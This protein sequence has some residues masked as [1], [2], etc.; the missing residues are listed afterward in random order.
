[1]QKAVDCRNVPHQVATAKWILATKRPAYYIEPRRASENS[2][3]IN[4]TNGNMVRTSLSL[5]RLPAFALMAVWLIGCSQVEPGDA[6]SSTGS[7]SSGKNTASERGATAYQQG[8]A[9][10]E[11]LEFDKAIEFLS[12]AIKEDDQNAD[13]YF[14]IG[15]CLAMQKRDNEAIANLDQAIAMKPDFAEAYCKRGTIHCDHER[16]D[17]GQADLEKA[18]TLDPSLADGQFLLGLILWSIRDNPSA[19]LPHLDKAA[20]LDPQNGGI[21]KSRALVHK[22]LGNLTEAEEDS[23]RARKLGA[24]P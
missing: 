22:Q 14:R 18:V 7:G 15:V 6:A 1:M 16:N 4:S 5:A 8:I 9:A 21:Y 10:Q 19:A 20:E 2:L 24:S 23:L 3:L 17:A 11:R 12:T 13:A